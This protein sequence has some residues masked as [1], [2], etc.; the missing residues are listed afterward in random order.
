M[1]PWGPDG[2]LA[3]YEQAVVLLD[4][5]LV[6]RRSLLTPNAKGTYGRAGSD[7]SGT[8]LYFVGPDGTIS[9]ASL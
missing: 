3:Q 7:P 2:L 4:R 9:L 5:E 1:V 6:T 8:K